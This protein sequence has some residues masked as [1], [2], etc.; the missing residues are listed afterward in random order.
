MFGLGTKTRRA[1]PKDA[2][3]VVARLNAD[4]A[5]IPEFAKSNLI[6][7]STIDSLAVL[8][9]QCVL[10]GYEDPRAPDLQLAVLTKYPVVHK[11]SIPMN[12]S[13]RKAGHLRLQLD[14]KK[15]LSLYAI[16]LDDRLESIRLLQV[17]SLVSQVR[18][19][20]TPCILAM[21][22]FNAMDGSSLFA[23]FA[24]SWMVRFVSQYV[25]N[26][27][28]Y[29]IVSRVVGMATGTT[30]DVFKKGTKLKDLDPGLQ[31]TISAKQAG[32]EWMP[33]V[34]LAKIDWL[35]GRGVEH[36]IHYRVLED[37]GSDHRPIEAE[38]EL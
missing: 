10:F 33:S 32:I 20:I 35:F 8:G 3:A 38:I 11:R 17:E 7:Q 26:G 1:A 36:V 30:I 14:D 28:L 4:I 21:G 6:D 25:P 22:D 16:H 9:Y 37:V 23:R 5:V 19:D 13:T 29:T 2:L 27:Q 15:E 31:R 18:S 12:G 34:R 24:R